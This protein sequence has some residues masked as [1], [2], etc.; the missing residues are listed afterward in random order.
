LIGFGEVGQR[1]A[2]D[3]HAGGHLDLNAWDVLFVDPS[4]IPSR[5]L[6]GDAVRAGRTA[7]DALAGAT[8]VI[9][10]VTAAEC[11]AAARTASGS[12]A[13]GALY[14]DL[15]SVSPRTKAEAA[16]AV[17]AVGGR[18]VEAAVMA[19]IG[20]KGI[21]SPI[22]LG[23]PHAQA[24]LPVGRPLGFAGA[25]VFSAVIG[26]ASAAKMCRSVIIKGIE[27]L[28]TESLLAA[29]RYGVE[30][31]VLTSLGDFLPVADW[32]ARSR[33][34]ISRALQHGRRRAAD[35]REVAITVREAGI[36]PWMSAACAERQDWAAGHAAATSNES[37]ASMLDAI[38]ATVPDR[39]GLTI[40]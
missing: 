22:L 23:G 27:A 3:L 30:D 19:P 25:E 17:S 29:R 11:V 8:V 33:Y 7:P 20:P 38:L 16:A 10:A 4:S 39:P 36:E 31:A 12:L 2:S 35:M 5:A 26:R 37:L 40:C 1:L 34:M 14:L 9:S 18:Y 6:R 24:F 13:P 21:A 15:N 28:L 32:P